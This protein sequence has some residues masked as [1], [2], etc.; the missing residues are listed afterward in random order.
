M[1]TAGLG[2]Y[3][4][5]LDDRIYVIGGKPS[6]GRSVTDVVEIYRVYNLTE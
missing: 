1:P 6:L 5:T 3:T 2:S 4:V